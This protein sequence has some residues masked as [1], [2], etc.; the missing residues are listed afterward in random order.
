MSVESLDQ[1]GEVGERSGQ[2]IDL[3][4]DEALRPSPE[5]CG[6]ASPRLKF[7]PRRM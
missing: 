2:P 1:L 4:D 5:S 3:I 6:H 7:R